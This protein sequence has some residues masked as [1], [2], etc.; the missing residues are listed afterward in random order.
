MKYKAAILWLGSGMLVAWGLN[1]GSREIGASQTYIGHLERAAKTTS[2][3][4]AETELNLAIDNIEVRGLTDGYTSIF[5]RTPDEDIGFWHTNLLDAR[6]MLARAKTS[7]ALT[8]SNALIKLHEMLIEPVNDGTAV[9][10]P[11]GITRYPMNTLLFIV[12][13]AAV[14]MISISAIAIVVED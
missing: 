6:D 7:D 11:S 10:A 2:V 1:V 12:G 4:T 9:R 13:W 5:F 14:L 3:E 8:Q